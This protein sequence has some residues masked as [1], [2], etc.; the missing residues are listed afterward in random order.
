M[1]DPR[2]PAAPSP[3]GIT[4]RCLVLLLLSVCLAAG[5]PPVCP[6]V[7][8]SPGAAPSPMAPPSPAEIHGVLDGQRFWARLL[9]PDANF[10]GNR[11]LQ[12]VWT[13]PTP[14]QLAGAHQTDVP[15]VLVDDRLRVVA[16]NG[17]DTLN[18]ARRGKDAYRVGRETHPQGDKG[19]PVEETRSIAGPPAWDLHLAPILLAL[20][21]TEGGNA[22]ERVVDLFGPRHGE[23]LTISWNSGA[24]ALA[25]L[26]ATVTA[27]RGRL[28][29]LTTAGPDGQ[30][31]TLI[32]VAGWLAEPAPP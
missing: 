13:P 29:R 2:E 26:T 6:T 11:V 7:P 14:E 31:R 25:G 24:I 5:E 16:W 20:A 22:H 15:F 27:E 3:V 32:E 18:Q 8:P 4:M 10:G 19:A 17:R 1:S 23:N 12:V 21:W 28:K 30:Q 9:P